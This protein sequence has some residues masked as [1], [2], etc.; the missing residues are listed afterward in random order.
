MVCIPGMQ[1]W[2]R[3][4]FNQNQRNVLRQQI[5]KE[6]SSD[7]IDTEKTFLK[8]DVQTFKKILSN[9]QKKLSN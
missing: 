7:H 3:I 1:G 8:N 5:K 6:K 2:H 4:Y 9:L